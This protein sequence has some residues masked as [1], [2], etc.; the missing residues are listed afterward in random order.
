MQRVLVI[1]LIIVGVLIGAC[2][3]DKPSP[4][5][6][7]K[8]ATLRWVGGKCQDNYIVYQAH[9]GIWQYLDETTATKYQFELKPQEDRTL[10]VSGIC[11]TGSEIGEW[12]SMEE[13]RA[14]W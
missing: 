10:T 2:S 1:G 6:Q 4:V 12:M 13:V 11:Q 7:T 14:K 8:I 9:E 3:S 5:P